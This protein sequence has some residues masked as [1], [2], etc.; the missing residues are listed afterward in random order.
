MHSGFITWTYWLRNVRE[1]KLERDTD[2]PTKTSTRE[3]NAASTADGSTVEMGSSGV[4]RDQLPCRL[5]IEIKGLEWFIYNRSPA[6]DTIVAALTGDGNESVGIPPQ[7][8]GNTVHNG[9]IDGMKKRAFANQ[10][11]LAKIA[12][13]NRNGKR[14][15]EEDDNNQSSTSSETSSI[16]PGATK[17]AFQNTIGDSY[18]LQMLPVHIECAKAAVVLGNENTKSIFIT[19]AERFSGD[20]DATT[21]RAPDL[22]K[23]MY[24]FK[25][26]E[27]VIQLKPN[28][29]FKE[30]QTAA[31][32]RE[33]DE[34]AEKNRR[35]KHQTSI[36]HRFKR[37]TWH[38]LQDRVQ[39]FSSSV[40]TF[41][42]AAPG[43]GHQSFEQFGVES[44]HQWQGDRKSV[45]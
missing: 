41:S 16:T 10:T 40:E 18:M 15:E 39:Y 13:N 24:N 22:Y 32:S 19:K 43:T 17:D 14:N 1:L 23:Q 3:G 35:P 11:N 36:W 27:P 7:D 28:E 26:I 29:D 6:Y 4:P 44:G 31:A 2:C 33:K 30:D 21:C 42:S 9:P 5:S 8:S 34:E 45:V 25:L 38:I 12:T 37:K 20:I